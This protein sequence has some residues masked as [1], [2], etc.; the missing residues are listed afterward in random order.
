MP[1]YFDQQHRRYRFTFNRVVNGQRRRASRLLP[2]GWSREQADRFDVQETARLYAIATGVSER[3]PLISEAVRL[4]LEHRVPSL[5]F[6]RGTALALH[7]LMP[8]YQG[9]TLPELPDV[10]REYQA[11]HPE[12]QAA[13]VRNQLAYLRAA[14]R[15]AWKHHGTG[16]QDYSRRMTL[17]AVRNARHVYLRPDE[18]QRLLA[19]CESDELRALIR[20]AYYTGLRWVKELLPRERADIVREGGD[21]WLRVPDTKTGRPHMA[22]IHPAARRDLAHLPFARHWRTYYAGFEAARTKAGMPELHMHDL[23]HSMA[24]ALISSGATLSEVGAALGHSTPQSTARYAHLYPERLAAVVR[25]MPTISR[26][27]RPK[28]RASA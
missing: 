24:S 25:K 10:A 14:C 9:R 7:R 16:D 15:Y 2:A 13:T 21:V 20:L 6:S 22:W 12:L 18:L 27:T 11:A 8:H 1:I 26:A 3:Q 19:A 5:R 23:R 4:Y 17:P 28:K